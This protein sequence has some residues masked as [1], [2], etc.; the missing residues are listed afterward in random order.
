MFL[1]VFGKSSMKLWLSG[2]S[3]YSSPGSCT[4]WPPGS[5]TTWSSNLCFVVSVQECGLSSLFSSQADPQ[6]FA[7]IAYFNSCSC[8]TYCLWKIPATPSLPTR[9]QYSPLA[10][11]EA[12]FVARLYCCKGTWKQERARRIDCAPWVLCSCFRRCARYLHIYLN[13]EHLPLRM[14]YCALWNGGLARC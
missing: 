1:F 12:G 9:V 13:V 7:C 8:G 6:F 14:S 5:F 10:V 2:V 4:C 3:T 11:A